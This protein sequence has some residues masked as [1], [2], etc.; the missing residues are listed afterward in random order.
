M[1]IPQ[2]KHSLGTTAIE[3]L[4]DEQHRLGAE[5]FFEETEKDRKEARYKL[6]EEIEEAKQ[7]VIRLQEI[8]SSL[9]M[10]I[11]TIDK[12]VSSPPFNPSYLILVAVQ[13]ECSKVICGVMPKEN[14]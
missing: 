11:A 13:E 3:M 4:E 6:I 9:L 7:E 12:I 1:S 14:V 8:A 10:S 2:T 5:A